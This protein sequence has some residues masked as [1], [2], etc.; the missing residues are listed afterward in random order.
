MDVIKI[1]GKSFLVLKPVNEV[2]CGY[3]LGKHDNCNFAVYE[4][5]EVSEESIKRVKQMG[6][7][8]KSKVGEP[9]YSNPIA[10]FS[11]TQQ[12]RNYLTQLSFLNSTVEELATLFENVQKITPNDVE[13]RDFLA[14]IGENEEE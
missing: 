7:N 13:L 12:M 9:R 14:N 2:D 3:L 5:R 11:T 6:I 1:K 4:L 8:V 10:F